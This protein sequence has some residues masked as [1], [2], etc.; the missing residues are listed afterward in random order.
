MASPI[1]ADCRRCRSFT[2]PPLPP[3]ISL[4]SFHFDKQRLSLFIFIIFA[5][6]PTPRYAAEQARVCAREQMMLP[7]P[8]PTGAFRDAAAG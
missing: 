8:M 3:L 7:P 5:A 4:T 6:A 1:F 2:F